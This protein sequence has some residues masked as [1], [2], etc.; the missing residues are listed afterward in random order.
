MPWMS[1]LRALVDAATSDQLPE[2]A[3]DL[4]REQALV[5]ARV[6][7]PV[8]PEAGPNDDARLL[9]VRE[10]AERLGVSVGWLYRYKG[11]LP[12][13]RKLGGRTLRFD[14]QGLERW[15]KT[16]AAN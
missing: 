7:K 14:P 2:L 16:R 5:L 12:F 11:R 9:T 6:A 8:R 13:A 1:E 10:A 3:A 4:S 15:S